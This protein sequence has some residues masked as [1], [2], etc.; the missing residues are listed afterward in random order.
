MRGRLGTVPTVKSFTH[1]GR[2]IDVRYRSNLY[3]VL[4][5]AGFAATAW[6]LD[7]PPLAAA[8]SAFLAWALGRELDPDRLAP[9]TIAAV[10]GGAAAIYFEE[11]S[12]GALYLFL[13]SARILA[14]TTGLAPLTGDLAVHV[15]IAGFVARSTVGWIAALVLAAAV[16]LDARAEPAA[17]RSHDGWAAA[18]AVTATVVA[19][20]SGFDLWG[21]GLAAAWAF[22][23]LGTVGALITIRPE[24][25]TAKGDLTREPLHA[26]R[27]SL[28]RQTTLAGGVAIAA[29]TLAPGIA[30]TGAV[31]TTLSVAGLTRLVSR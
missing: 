12:L 18:I 1:L 31:W 19:G 22:A 7:A 28:A 14:R 23:G 25:V 5:S 2:I 3:A 20:I 8:G 17:P 21:D 24:P 27:V 26:N 29:F 9:A 6:L 10:R 30:A 13:I 16:A 11:A 4:V 15:L